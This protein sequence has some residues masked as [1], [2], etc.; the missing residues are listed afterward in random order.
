MKFCH[1]ADLHFSVKPEKLEEVMRCSNAALS[2]I[3]DS[4]PDLIILAGDTC[5][6]HD[7]PIR[8][9]S[10]TARALIQFVLACADIAP[11]A[12]VMGTP[13]HDRRTP[14]LL[15]FLRGANQIYVADKIE[16]VQLTSY[17]FEPYGN[18]SDAQA[19][20]K[21]VLTFL[22]SPDKAKIVG[23]FGGTSKQ[24]TTMAAKEILQDTLAYIG[25]VNQTVHPDVP[26]IL[27][28]HGM[29][30]GSEYSSGTVATGEDLEYGIH[31]LNQTN[32]DYKAFG[33]VHKFQEFPG[34]IVYAGSLGR[35]NFGEKEEKGFVMA[36]FAEG[37][38]GFSMTFCP[39][40]ARRFLFLETTW[41]D[42]GLD[43][44][45][46]EVDK[47]LAECQG[48]DVR[49]R[50]SIPE[51]E[52]HAVNRTDIAEK[53]IA[54]GA[55]NVRVEPTIIPKIRQRAA[56]ISQICTL[57]DKILKWG[58]T[59]GVEI[60]KRVLSIA[61]TIEGDEVAE[62]VVSARATVENKH[63]VLMKSLSTQEEA[64]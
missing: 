42:G 8:I 38:N 18:R 55:R 44:I 26:R 25:E 51:E 2:S 47:G 36:Q 21:C 48:A 63:Q 10:D 54:A 23:T 64:A 31:D 53:F 35:L 24:L 5:D 7:G 46:A 28:G 19:G 14:E 52:R 59:V 49:L 62:L 33:H 1:L 56:G 15:R 27:I 12:V 11:V 37:R 6:E 30:T 22:P 17:G 50:Y 34:H 58:D 40:P 29:I 32:A 57:S 16:M 61:D 60:P 4:S 20:T 9:D 3:K 45:A 41:E 43:A 13:S 39:T